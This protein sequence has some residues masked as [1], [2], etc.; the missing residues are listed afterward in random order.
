LH[1]RFLYKNSDPSSRA[2]V[3]PKREDPLWHSVSALSGPSRYLRI[4]HRGAPLF[5]VSKRGCVRHCGR[6]LHSFA[7]MSPRRLGVSLPAMKRSLDIV[8]DIPKLP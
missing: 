8:F 2:S 3:Q 5:L 6:G 4:G 1:V 7:M